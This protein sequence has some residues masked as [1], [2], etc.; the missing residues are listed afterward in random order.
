MSLDYLNPMANL[1]NEFIKILNNVVIKYTS[2]A[3][4][5]E[6]E[7]ERQDAES[8][9]DAVEMTDNFNTYAEFTDEELLAVG[10]Y[11]YNLRMKCIQDK[12]NIPI[13]TYDPTTGEGTR[14]R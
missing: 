13:D 2:R 14:F 1:Y 6:T 8:Y 7:F 4:A 3:I 9:I 5:E 11:D 12:N 10:I